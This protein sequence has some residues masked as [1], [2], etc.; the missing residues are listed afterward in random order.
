MSVNTILGIISSLAH[1][2]VDLLHLEAVPG[3]PHSGGFALN[4][5][6]G[7][8]PV[9][10]HGLFWNVAFAPAGYGLTVDTT[11]NHYDRAVIAFR[12]FEQLVDATLASS[13]IFESREAQGYYLFV[14]QTPFVIDV[15]IAPG[16]TVNL[17]WLVFF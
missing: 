10:A 3:N 2:P 1:P 4:R 9:D 11:G 13:A 14:G 16:V 8:K 5:V 12:E 6:R 7:A 17:S 15:E